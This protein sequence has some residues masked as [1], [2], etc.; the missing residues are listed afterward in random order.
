MAAIRGVYTVVMDHAAQNFHL[1]LEYFTRVVLYPARLRKDL[2]ELL[3]GYATN[4]AGLVEQN[5][6]RA[7]RA[8][9]KGYDISV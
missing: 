1:C 9:I 2:F 5:S 6:S 8:L 3:L 7:R 4:D